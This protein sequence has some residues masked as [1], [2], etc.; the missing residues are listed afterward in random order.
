MFLLITQ[1]LTYRRLSKEGIKEH[2]KSKK[3]VRHDPKS[4][5]I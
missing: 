1:N 3:G 5:N 2:G 4:I